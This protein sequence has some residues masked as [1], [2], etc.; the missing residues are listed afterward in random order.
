MYFKSEFGNGVCMVIVAS[1]DRFKVA[2]E[3]IEFQIVII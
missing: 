1:I 2:N 3:V